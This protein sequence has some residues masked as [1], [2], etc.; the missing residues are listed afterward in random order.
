[1]SVHDPFPS[2]PTFVQHAKSA[3][4]DFTPAREVLLNP[5]A[6]DTMVA[7]ACDVLAESAHWQDIRAVADQRNLLWAT[8]GSEVMQ[9]A[10]PVLDYAVEYDEDRG[11]KYAMWKAF[12][13]LAAVILA[14]VILL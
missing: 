14:A 3:I 10:V 1:M 7:M 9:R 2:H 13:V 8:T 4:D 12:A 6:S 5:Y 11:P